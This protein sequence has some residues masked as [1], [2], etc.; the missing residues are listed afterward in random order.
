MSEQANPLTIVQRRASAALGDIKE[1][2]DD[3]VGLLRPDRQRDEELLLPVRRLVRALAEVGQLA[4]APVA[5]LVETQVK[6]IDS[7]RALADQ[8]AAWAELQHQLADRIAA[9]AQ[10]QRQA[11]NSLEAA[12][13]PVSGV[14]Q[15]TTRLLKD[16]A[17]EPAP[18]GARRAKKAR[19]A[20][21]R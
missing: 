8:M 20:P 17:G 6:L 2:A 1:A 4:V 5:Q 3:L 18:A 10:L 15:M 9:W 21:G 19:P 11:A 14:T 12:M 13:A 7:Q 16:A